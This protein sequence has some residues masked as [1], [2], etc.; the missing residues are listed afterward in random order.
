MPATQPLSC[1]NRNLRGGRPAGRPVPV[2]GL[3]ADSSTHPR[4]INS[5]SPPSK[6]G[7]DKPVAAASSV[8]VALPPPARSSRRISRELTV[9]RI[10]VSLRTRPRRTRVGQSEG[11]MPAAP[12]YTRCRL[13]RR[14][15]QSATVQGQQRWLAMGIRMAGCPSDR[16]RILASE[17]TPWTHRRQPE[18]CSPHTLAEVATMTAV[19]MLDSSAT[20]S[21]IAAARSTHASR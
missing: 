3:P 16:M 5:S 20:R 10:D 7:R 15:P 1:R 19:R 18:Y 17:R 12:P 8:S 11:D 6:V 21:R 2:D 4:A 14:N 9:R 13:P